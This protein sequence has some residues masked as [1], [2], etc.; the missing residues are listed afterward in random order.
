MF[1]PSRNCGDRNAVRLWRG[2]K[3]AQLAPAA[4]A[5][6]DE[7]ALK[8]GDWSRAYWPALRRFFSK[9]A[10]TPADSDDMVQEVFLRLA[11]QPHLNQIQSPEGY[12]FRTAYSVLH[13]WRR[14][15]RVRPDLSGQLEYETADEDWI[16]PERSAI[17]RDELTHI[18]A[19]LD[20][21]NSRTRTIFVLYHFE[22]HTHVEISRKLGVAVRTIEDHMARANR[23][24]ISA[25]EV[26]N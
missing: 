2:M 3:D 19:V 5:M 4:M 16:S 23:A 13:D 11:P 20:R 17:A 26:Q 18:V 8:L 14:R 15:E 22:N 24:L 7:N 21:M 12:L 9:R 6:R 1:S 25:H 10:P